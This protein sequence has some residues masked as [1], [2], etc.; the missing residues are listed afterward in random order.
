M[1]LY[2]TGTL[3][4]INSAALYL[5]S[6]LPLPDICHRA[7]IA[8][9][10]TIGSID[11]DCILSRQVSGINI[12]YSDA[13]HALIKCDVVVE[14]GK[15]PKWRGFNCGTTSDLYASGNCLGTSKCGCQRTHRLFLGKLAAVNN[16]VIEGSYCSVAIVMVALFADDNGVSGRYQGGF[17]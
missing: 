1:R 14:I 5:N 15:W 16:L 11:Y 7:D 17:L 9:N 10:R 6:E 8:G 3:P 2:C 12:V 4:C 13:Q